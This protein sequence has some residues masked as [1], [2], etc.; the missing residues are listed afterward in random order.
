MSNWNYEVRVLVCTYVIK[1]R[2]GNWAT[3]CCFC[4]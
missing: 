3:F 4:A 2:I 1:V